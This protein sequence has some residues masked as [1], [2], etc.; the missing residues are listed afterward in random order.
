MKTCSIR[1]ALIPAILG[2]GCGGALA[3]TE[4]LATTEAA[5][6]GARELDADAL[7]RGA[8]HIKLAEEQLDK[9]KGYIE[10]DM[11]QRADLAL[12]RAQ[13]DAELAIAL[14]REHEMNE[15]TRVARAR[16]EQLKAR[17]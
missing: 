11:Y 4:R 14:A 15:K 5:I 12:R 7:P 16:L 13:A 9:A 8:L 6:R 2:L 10:D 1:I 3:P 17:R